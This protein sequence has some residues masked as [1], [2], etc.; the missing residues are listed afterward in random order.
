MWQQKI[1]L[2]KFTIPKKYLHRRHAQNELNR[3]FI[4]IFV[5]FRLVLIGNKQQFGPMLALYLYR[6]FRVVM[7]E[8]FVYENFTLI[9]VK[10]VGCELTDN[11]NCAKYLRLTQNT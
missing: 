1:Q 8:I 3:K 7:S 9:R 10:L 2:V 5:R 6:I 11:L 4:Y